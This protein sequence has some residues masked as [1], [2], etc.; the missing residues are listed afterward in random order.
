MFFCCLSS[1]EGDGLTSCL[2]LGWIGT[3][4]CLCRFSALFSRQRRS[5]SRPSIFALRWIRY[6]RVNWRTLLKDIRE[7]LLTNRLMLHISSSLHRTHEK[8][9]S[10]LTDRTYCFHSSIVQE[11]FLALSDHVNFFFFKWHGHWLVRAAV[12]SHIN[13]GFYCPPSPPAPHSS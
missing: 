11:F 12:L 10:R 6:S 2:R 7:S 3:W 4:R 8:R 9:V 13:L 1:S 5:S